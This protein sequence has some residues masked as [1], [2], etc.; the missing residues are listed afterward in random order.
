[1]ILHNIYDYF[2]FKTHYFSNNQLF[3]QILVKIST[4]ILWI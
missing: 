2:Y 1:M 3:D 4:N